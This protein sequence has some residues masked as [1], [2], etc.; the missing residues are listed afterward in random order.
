MVEPD[1]P[2]GRVPVVDSILR[3]PEPVPAAAPSERDQDKDRGQPTAPAE[4][5]PTEVSD[6]L[7][8]ERFYKDKRDRIAR[9][10]ALTL[11]D[12][13]LG[14]EAADEAMA[15]AY[16]RWSKVN[17]F[18]D[19]AAWAYRVGLNWAT[20]VVRRR[21][22]A[23]QPHAER[24]PTDI[25]PIEEPTVHAALNELDVKHRAVVVCRFYLGLNEA[26]TAAGLGIRP[27]TAKSRL[28]RA[29]RALHPRLAH[30]RQEESQ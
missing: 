25:G 17:R 24:G 2:A 14:A 20:S 16:Q 3:L 7:A 15:R 9:A 26:E 23:P 30:L 13:H 18:D 12:S 5:S 28:H 29:L 21:H 27:G 6:R 8:F 22:R 1:R 10:L 4:A 11:N 19:P